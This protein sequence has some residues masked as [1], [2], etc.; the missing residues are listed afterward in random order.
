MCP[1]RGI[2]TWPPSLKWHESLKEQSG[3]GTLRLSLYTTASC[4]ALKQTQPHARQRREPCWTSQRATAGWDFS[5]LNSITHIQSHLWDVI[6]CYVIILIVV[7]CVTF[8]I[9]CNV[10][11]VL[12]LSQLFCLHVSP[13]E[14]FP[15]H[16]SLFAYTISDEILCEMWNLCEIPHL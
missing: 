6:I 2:K 10:Q 8:S 7:E 14:F 16:F 3:C 9:D 4:R 5:Q 1:I 15:F 12:K 11:C 13:I